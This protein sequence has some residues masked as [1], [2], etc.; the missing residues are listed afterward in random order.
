MALPL[1]HIKTV[2]ASHNE[3]HA[4]LSTPVHKADLWSIS[5]YAEGGEEPGRETMQSREC[6]EVLGQRAG[7]V[8]ALRP[9]H[10]SCFSLLCKM[11]IKIPQHSLGFWEDYM[12]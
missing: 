11:E 10:L 7:Q 3:E 8:T 4:V 9:C 1:A 12:N 5:A 6:R 2:T